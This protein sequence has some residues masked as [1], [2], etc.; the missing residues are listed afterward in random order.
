MTLQHRPDVQFII[1]GDGPLASE[2]QRAIGPEHRIK[3]LSFQ[4]NMQEI[5]AMMD[6]FALS[7][8]WEGL[9]RALTEAMIMGLPVAATA[10]GG[11]P[12]LVIHGG[13]PDCYRRRVS[14]L[15]W[16]ITLYGCWIILKKRK[17]WANVPES[18]LC[19][20]LVQTR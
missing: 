11:V 12:E 14:Q 10:V 6:V 15:N 7:S 9:G 3:L 19:L 5:F 17:E 18:G 4:D 20:Y 16:L 8:L 13:R 1:I 2:M